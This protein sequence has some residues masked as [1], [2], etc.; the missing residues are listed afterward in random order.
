V[1]AEG[2]ADDRLGVDDC[3]RRERSVSCTPGADGAE[4][5]GERC[6]GCAFAGTNRMAYVQMLVVLWLYRA[7]T[8]D[9][10]RCRVVCVP[11]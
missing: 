10:D 6:V 1:E 5:S 11:S 2:A 4:V 7:F 9:E 3:P 8:P